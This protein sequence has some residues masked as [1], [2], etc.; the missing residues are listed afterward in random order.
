MSAVDVK[1]FRVMLACLELEVNELAE[2][3]GYDARYVSNVVNGFTK[4][5][6]AFRRA[7]GETIG[8][9]V[10]GT[11]EP[12]SAGRYPAEPL[13]ALIRQRASEAPRKRDFYRDIGVS[14]EAL[15]RHATFDGVFV[16]RVC[17]ALGV[18]PSALYG[19]EYSLARAS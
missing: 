1:T 13:V 11:Y 5:S 12:P 6:P 15:R 8:T 4:A 2:R 19:E 10:F 7:F 17:C 9:L 14:G 16:D 3:M 18:H